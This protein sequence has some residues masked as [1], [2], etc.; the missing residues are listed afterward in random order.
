MKSVIVC[1]IFLAFVS[2]LELQVDPRL[3]LENTYQL[4]CINAQGKVTYQIQNL[5]K[6]ITLND[7]VLQINSNGA[8]ADGFYPVRVKAQDAA[9]QTDERIVVIVVRRLVQ[10]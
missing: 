7:N 6:G 9:G 3:V 10:G 4:Q 1:L 5:P 2:A 8:A